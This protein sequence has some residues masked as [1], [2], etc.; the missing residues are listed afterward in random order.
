[1]I[2][3]KLPKF[4]V[5]ADKATD[6]I[7]GYLKQEEKKHREFWLDERIGDNISF[8]KG[9]VL[10]AEINDA[11]FKVPEWAVH[12]IEYS[13]YEDLKGELDRCKLDQIEFLTEHPTYK[14]SK[15]LE[16]E[17]EQLKEEL[18][19]REKSESQLI[20]ERYILRIR[21]EERKQENEQLKTK[22][23]KAVEALR[24]CSIDNASRRESSFMA[25]QTL[26]E[27]EGE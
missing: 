8:T 13:A 10:G 25:R 12:A 3:E 27:I 18:G 5:D 22:L 26:K 7:E 9:T 2:D 6:V 14:L 16:K 17:N 15:E 20:C 1:M 21:I 23:G 24:F 11:S 19:R 4:I